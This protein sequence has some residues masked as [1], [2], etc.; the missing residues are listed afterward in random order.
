MNKLKSICI[1]VALALAGAAA[2]AEESSVGEAEGDGLIRGLDFAS[3]SLVVG[4]HEYSVGVGTKVEIDGTFGAFTM[5]EPG[6]QT[7]FEYNNKPDG[8]R[9]IVLLK[10]YS[11]SYVFAEGEAPDEF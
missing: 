9:E 11:D 7:T 4:G 1:G 3:N 2:T 10:A 6:M 8:R 5:L